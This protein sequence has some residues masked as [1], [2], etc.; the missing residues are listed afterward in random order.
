MD[1]SPNTT[2]DALTEGR[3]PP[4][5][6]VYETRD[7]MFS[8]RIGPY[9]IKGR[10]P[11]SVLGVRIMAHHCNLYGIAHGGLLMAFCDTVMGRAAAA[12]SEAMCATATLTSHFVQ[13]VALGAWL[14]GRVT[15][16]KSGKRSV[17]LRAD[18]TVD[19]AF[20]VSAEGLWQRVNLK[21]TKEPSS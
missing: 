10:Y 7:G 11:D 20:V 18:L 21:Q 1:T 4:G 19:G 9:F 8:S 16:L 14:E 15:V 5:F 3:P 6:K 17:F 12:A 13:P 2:S